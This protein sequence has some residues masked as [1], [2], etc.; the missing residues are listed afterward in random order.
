MNAFDGINIPI[1]KTDKIKKANK[2]NPNSPIVAVPS[3]GADNASANSR[4]VPILAHQKLWQKSSVR[5]FTYD[6]RYYHVLISAYGVHSQ[7]FLPVDEYH[8]LKQKIDKFLVFG[9]DL[10]INEYIRFCRRFPA[11]KAS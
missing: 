10:P 5:I 6:N 3:T 8:L 11:D 4:G 7:Y 1:V 2:A 9:H